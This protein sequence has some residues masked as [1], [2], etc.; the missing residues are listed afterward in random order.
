MLQ[1]SAFY[2]M[3]MAM[4]TCAPMMQF[5][6]LLLPLHKMLVSMGDEN[7]YTCF[8]QPCSTPLVDELTLCSPK[9]EFALYSMLSLL[10][11]HEHIYFIDSTQVKNFVAFEAAQAKKRSYHDQHLTDHFLPLAI[12]E[13]GFL[14][15]QVDVLLHN[16]ANAMW[17]FK[18]TKS[19]P[20]FV[21]VTFLCKFFS[22]TLQ[23][24][25][26][27]SI[28][29]WAIA[30]GLATSQLPPL[31]NAPPITTTDLLQGVDCWDKEILISSLC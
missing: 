11:Q 8:F 19:P 15:K 14:D 4:N 27:S 28:L 21:F 24:L 12:E 1:V 26:T 17:N 31:E 22:I 29:S 9:M 2:V 18:G 6:T 16:C 10:I 23:R 13:F 20:P 3:S 5:V 25:Q 7:N 30:V